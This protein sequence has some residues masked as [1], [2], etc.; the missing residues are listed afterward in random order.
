[1]EDWQEGSLA[2]RIDSNQ[3]EMKVTLDACLEKMEAGPEEQKSLAVHE[4]VEIFATLKKRKGG[5]L[6]HLGCGG[7]PRGM[8]AAART[9]SPA[10]QEWPGVRDPVIKDRRSNRS[11]RKSEPGTWKRRTFGRR[12]RAQSEGSHIIRNRNFV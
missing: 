4:E 9:I 2:S 3:G 10:V 12:H 1:M 6:L 8:I 7:K 11:E 5:R